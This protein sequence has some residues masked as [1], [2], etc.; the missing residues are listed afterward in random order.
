MKFSPI[1]KDPNKDTVTKEKLVLEFWIEAQKLFIEQNITKDV[2]Y[3]SIFASDI[4]FRNG[5]I[6]FLKI[7][8][9]NYIPFYIVSAGFS[10]VIEGMFKIIESL[11]DLENFDFINLIAKPTEFDSNNKLIKFGIPLVH[12]HSKNK[13]VKEKIGL[14]DKQN[15]ILIGDMIPDIDMISG[16][17]Y[18]TKL[19]IGYFNSL[20]E[21]DDLYDAFSNSYDIVIM[22]D[23]SLQPVIFILA[24]ILQDESLINTNEFQI[25]ESLFTS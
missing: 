9:N 18:K 12:F 17:D 4:T 5:I 19:L 14:N 23:A 8:A 3:K 15:C 1:E 20:N 10:P 7:I 24:K 16:I 6:L 13:V 2:I 11:S 21:N 25:L 22:G